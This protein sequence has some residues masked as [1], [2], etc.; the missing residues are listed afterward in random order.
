M[1]AEHYERLVGEQLIEW[2]R[3]IQ[4]AIPPRDRT[5]F[6]IMRHTGEETMVARPLYLAELATRATTLDAQA[7]YLAAF[8][9]ESLA[10][11]AA[12]PPG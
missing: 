2:R 12:H 4:S 9:D 1:P 11:L 3:L 7:D 10:F 8:V 5:G 6:D